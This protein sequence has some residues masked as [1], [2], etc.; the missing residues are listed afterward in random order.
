[1]NIRAFLKDAQRR[2]FFKYTAEVLSEALELTKETKI[3]AFILAELFFR[4]LLRA[5]SRIRETVNK[6]LPDGE[7][8]FFD[9]NYSIDMKEIPPERL[10][11]YSS[12]TLSEKT[13]SAL[14]FRLE[15]FRRM[16]GVIPLI[17]PSGKDGAFLPFYLEKATDTEGAAVTDLAGNELAEWSRYIQSV[18]DDWKIRVEAC[19]EDG[20]FTG[21][22]LMLPVQ[23]AIWRKENKEEFPQYNI[24]RLLSTGAFDHRGMVIPVD[25]SVKIE[26]AQGVFSN[27]VFCIPESSPAE[28]AQK[29]REVILL[30][31]QTKEHLKENIKK[32]IEEKRL[33]NFSLKYAMSR[34]KE[35]EQAVRFQ[36]RN[37]WK[38][39][40][41]QL[42][43]TF[44]F[45]KLRHRKEY[46]NHLMLLSAACCHAGF[47]E[48]A[49][50]LN[51]KAVNYALENG[52]K[53]ELL[54]LEIENLVL[55]L[56]QEKF[57]AISQISPGLEER[58]T[59]FNDNDLLMR[60]YGTMGQV[61]AYGAT[62]GYS[63]FSRETA[64]RFFVAAV[65]FACKK[66][67]EFDIAQDTNY[68]HL[69]YALFSP[70][71]LEE[72]EAFEEAEKQ[73]TASFCNKPQEYFRQ[74]N[75][76]LRQKAFSLSRSYLLT[77]EIPKYDLKALALNGP[78]SW[79][80]A[81]WNKYMGT[82]AAASGNKEQARKLFEEALQ[83]LPPSKDQIL[84]FIRMT[85][86]SQAFC[87]S[88]ISSYKDSALQMLYESSTDLLHY[89]NTA[90][91]WAEYLEN[92]EVDRLQELALKYWY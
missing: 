3:K 47:T 27:Y 49:G 53:N 56:D 14:L 68:L 58:L 52:F 79:L 50:E 12:N 9:C 35:L 10:W 38:G 76:L 45:G 69:W 5:D 87:S 19:I 33:A 85:I 46:L 67:N 24:L 78:D 39:L 83:I 84:S 26:S 81:V 43:S 55:L 16:D 20:P 63:C 70:G 32:I 60:F 8:Y 31:P 48:K 71:T 77:G 59:H 74:K 62:A 36:Q 91:K 7:L 86:F 34:Q 22:S 92:E 82:L 30:P 21:N 41:N 80:K 13:H 37:N 42:E 6:Y 57:A 28:T 88:G 17:L 23:L 18:T 29:R 64:K 75:F 44:V 15:S 73:I 65:E 72:Q 89:H 61:N 66:E 1:M 11:N 4:N 54:R 51:Q 40:I 90:Q 2:V 25:A